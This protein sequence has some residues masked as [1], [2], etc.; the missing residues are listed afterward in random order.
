MTFKDVIRF[1]EKRKRVLE[2]KPINMCHKYLA[3]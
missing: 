1:Y 2:M 3:R